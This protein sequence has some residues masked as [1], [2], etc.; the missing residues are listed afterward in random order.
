MP[1]CTKGGHNHAGWPAAGELT[2]CSGER[3]CGYC[4]GTA[5]SKNWVTAYNLRAHV[6]GQHTD[7]GKLD[8]GGVTLL[9]YTFPESQRKRK[10]RSASVASRSRKE[11]STSR[12]R[13][14]NGKFVAAGADERRSETPGPRTRSQTPG[15]HGRSRTP[16]ACGRGRKRLRTEEGVADEEDEEMGDGIETAASNVEMEMADGGADRMAALSSNGAAA[17]TRSKGTRTRSQAG[18]LTIEVPKARS[19][20]TLHG[21]KPPAAASKHV[22]IYPEAK[23]SRGRIVDEQGDTEEDI[24]SQVALKQKHRKAMGLKAQAED[25]QAD[26]EEDL[27]ALRLEKVRQMKAGTADENYHVLT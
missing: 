19:N 22:A 1:G 13:G 3:S 27:L 15:A 10:E 24:V 14:G 21:P 18:K 23:A 8:Y 2:I 9:G 26:Y 5:G 17:T 25:A 6:Y 12:T 7:G 4:K 11:A 20:I 16:G